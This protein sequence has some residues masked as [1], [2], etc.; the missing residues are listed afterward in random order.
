M[1]WTGDVQAVR[2][3]LDN[4]LTAMP[5]EY[6]LATGDYPLVFPI[7]LYRIPGRDKPEVESFF[8]QAESPQS[9][10]IEMFAGLTPMTPQLLVPRFE[11]E[12]PPAYG[13]IVRNALRIS[14]TVRFQPG[15][16]KIDSR[17]KR[18]FDDLANFLRRLD[19]APEQL[20]HLAFSESTGTADRDR[21]IADELGRLFQRELRSRNVRVGQTV[22]LGAVYPLAASDNPLGQRLNRRVETWVTP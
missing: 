14:T 9:H 19:I 7:L 17:T 4:R 5:N 6:G 10:V 13:D 11:N 16:L 18:S 15:S 3:T 1:M 2:F 21:D 12:L 8:A 22:A 20:R